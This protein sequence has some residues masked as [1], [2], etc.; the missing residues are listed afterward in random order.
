MT[1]EVLTERCSSDGFSGGL[2]EDGG[3]EI[4]SYSGRSDRNVDGNIKGN[5]LGGALC[6]DSGSYRRSSNGMSDD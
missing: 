3:A 6:A 4:G 1:A 2:S 5:P